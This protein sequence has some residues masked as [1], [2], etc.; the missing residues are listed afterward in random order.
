MDSN[1]I[2]NILLNLRRDK[3]EDDD[4][5][6]NNKKHYGDSS[7][8]YL[9][10]HMLKNVKLSNKTESTTQ[11]S[12]DDLYNSEQDDKYLYLPL[13]QDMSNEDRVRDKSKWL[14]KS[15]VC[16]HS[17]CLL[18]VKSISKGIEKISKKENLSMSHYNQKTVC[19]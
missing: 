9:P 16:I 3:D 5:N 10:I 13:N 6:E 1:D 2:R 4:A 11:V 18:R 8:T 12:E 19:L 15:K 17:L 14:L 7:E